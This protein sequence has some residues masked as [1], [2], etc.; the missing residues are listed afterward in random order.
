MAD[1]RREFIR[2]VD[3]LEEQFRK[4]DEEML[5]DK[6]ALIRGLTNDLNQNMTLTVKKNIIPS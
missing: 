1:I 3:I 6:M 4:I 5:K 2:K